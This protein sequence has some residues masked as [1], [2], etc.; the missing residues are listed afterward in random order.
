M[1]LRF[2]A[3]ISL[4]DALNLSDLQIPFGRVDVHTQRRLAEAEEVSSIPSVK[5]YRDGRGYVYDGPHTGGALIKYATKQTRPPVME[6]SNWREFNDFLNGKS[7]LVD[8]PE[9]STSVT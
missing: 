8:M 6:L 9:D 1:H 7:K 3:C 2:D 5:F 4:H